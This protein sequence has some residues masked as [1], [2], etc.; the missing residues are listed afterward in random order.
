MKEIADIVSSY[1]DVSHSYSSKH[2]SSKDASASSK[3]TNNEDSH[4]R[5][6]I[7]DDSTRVYAGTSKQEKDSAS[8]RHDQEKKNEKRQGD[9]DKDSHR[10]HGEKHKRN[11]IRK[12]RKHKSKKSAPEP[13]ADPVQ[14]FLSNAYTS[15]TAESQAS[16]SMAVNHTGWDQNVK[17]YTG[18]PVNQGQAFYGALPDKLLQPKYYRHQ[19][20]NL[21]KYTAEPNTHTKFHSDSENEEKEENHNLEQYNFLCST[22]YSEFQEAEAQQPNTPQM[23]DNLFTSPDVLHNNFNANFNDS[24]PDFQSSSTPY[25]SE[26]TREKTDDKSVK[27]DSALDLDKVNND[28]S[29]EIEQE[30]VSRN[31]RFSAGNLNNSNTNPHNSFTGYNGY[32]EGRNNTGTVA[33]PAALVQSVLPNGVTVFSRQ[34]RRTPKA[35]MF[36][37]EQQL[38][39]VATNRSFI[40]QVWPVY[41]SREKW[42]TCIF[43][44]NMTGIWEWRV[45]GLILHVPFSSHSDETLNQGPDSMV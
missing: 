44:K 17:K 4:S 31:D 13:S 10:G 20:H 7:K 27:N 25:T 40:V 6:K 30:S 3:K 1:T 37:K 33:T 38:N 39:D 14:L 12:H 16:E 9:S 42:F 2:E 5:D 26:N 11:R 15:Q 35:E 22:R 45:I 28:L 24:T 21:R 23:P 19:Y 43:N 18:N 8:N 29:N 36:T 32:A 41:E 34:R